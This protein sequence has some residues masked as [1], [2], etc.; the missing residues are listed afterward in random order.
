MRVCFFDPAYNIFIHSPLYFSSVLIGTSVD[1]VDMI[2]GISVICTLFALVTCVVVTCYLCCCYLL[3]VLL[4]LV[5]CVVVTCYLCCCYLILVLLLL[6]TCVVVT[7]YLCC[8][9]LLLV[10]LL[11]N[12]GKLDVNYKMGDT[13]LGST[14]TKD[15]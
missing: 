13:V 11:L 15:L 1:P 2:S 6:V 9:Y 12:F 7:C 10:L 3:L 8:C 4:L 14:T 5:T